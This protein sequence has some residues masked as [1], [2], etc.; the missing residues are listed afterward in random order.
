MRSPDGKMTKPG[1]Q[2]FRKSLSVLKILGITTFPKVGS[3]QL[4]LEIFLSLKMVNRFRRIASC[5]G[6]KK[7]RVKHTSKQLTLMENML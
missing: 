6:P 2:R 4:R 1:I 5:S 7:L 3:I